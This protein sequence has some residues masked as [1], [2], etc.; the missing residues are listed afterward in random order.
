[1]ATDRRFSEDSD[2]SSLEISHLDSST[3]LILVHDDDDDDYFGDNSPVEDNSDEPQF[4]VV[5]KPSVSPLSPSIVFLHLLSPLLKLG[6]MLIPSAAMPLKYAL[7]GIL[8][9][10][11][12][13]AFSQ[14]LCYLLSRHLRK[15]AMEDIVPQVFARGRGKEKHRNM[16]RRVTKLCVGATRLLLCIVYFQEAINN[17]LPLVPKALSISPRLVL[18][19]LFGVPLLPLSTT[20][21]FS[22]LRIIFASSVSIISYI[23]WFI[24]VAI[25][26]AHGTLR[27]SAG[28]PS[29]G[30]LWQGVT[31][32]AF[33]YTRP[34]T[35]H[36]S[37]ALARYKPPTVASK[38][39][40]YR[41][42]DTLSL[43]SLAVA[44]CMIL[45]LA[46]F[47]TLSKDSAPPSGRGVPQTKQPIA[48]FQTITLL[49]AIPPLIISMPTLPIPQRLH[50]LTGPTV[51]KTVMVVLLLASSILP[52]FLLSVV[53]N[54]ALI[55]TLCS[56][57][58]V[59]AFLHIVVHNFK[60]P[61]SIIVPTHPSTPITTH[62]PAHPEPSTP[63]SAND[64]LL[65][66]K[67][68]LLQKRQ[69]RKRLV[70]DLGAWIMVVPL[71]GGG[72]FWAVELVED[73]VRWL[74]EDKS[75]LGRVSLA[76]RI[77]ALSCRPRLF[78]TVIV[79]LNSASQ[80]WD[81]VHSPHN[82]L[83]D[84][85]PS[86]TFCA[87]DASDYLAFDSAI[88]Q[89][90][91][92]FPNVGTVG[93]QRISSHADIRGMQ[94]WMRSKLPGIKELVI[95]GMTVCRSQ[96]IEEFV[97]S[98]PGLE[99]LY[100]SEVL[101]DHPVGSI[102][103]LGILYPSGRNVPAHE[104]PKLESLALFTL[105]TRSIDPVKLALRDSSGHLRSLTFRFPD[106]D[107]NASVSGQFVS[108][109]DLRQ[110]PNLEK[111]R[112][113]VGL[114]YTGPDGHIAS[115]PDILRLFNQLS[116]HTKLRSV[117]IAAL[118]MYASDLDGTEDRAHFWHAVDVLF[119]DGK[120]SNFP[121]LKSLIIEMTPRDDSPLS[122]EEFVAY[123][124]NK[125]PRVKERGLLQFEQQSWF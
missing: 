108:M 107:N 56:T 4:Q 121:G 24:C 48:I 76:S 32:I 117:T 115:L 43:L 86:L 10:A 110:N 94:S 105:S 77:W 113:G 13:S 5:A 55:L 85:I 51:T 88:A 62:S 63:I 72:I 101:F 95:C 78:H 6:A 37:S 19:I 41:S 14:H 54:L 81:L 122:Y 25:A 26:H 119:G 20:L 17:I 50:H 114:A 44:T 125:L 42:F 120:N 79:Q 59:P 9:F 35:L 60:R 46:F 103:V 36:L 70:W 116:N 124:S 18:T 31:V 15:H 93:V 112:I 12:A 111:F 53:N 30:M 16:L 68:R 90:L 11:L 47:S 34:T 102:L 87:G 118:F 52:A 109:I 61:L 3:A 33:A 84:N 75:T 73:V 89:T 49:L 57:F 64:E 71:S 106:I 92:I 65:Q 1:M 2:R 27:S 97:R 104:V 28:W 23:A 74:R 29:M 123:M 82:T 99:S 100:L 45:P 39:P 22:S 58:F 21:S 8:V 80:F 40:K 67:E 7:P 83:I 66:R 69:F 91:P 38:S 96:S 98:F